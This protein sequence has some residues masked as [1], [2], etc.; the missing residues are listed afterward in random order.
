MKRGE[1]YRVFKGDT[2]DPKRSRVFIVVSR[3]VLIDS[4]YS[5]LICAPVFSSRDG[6][7]TQVPVGPEAGLKHESAIHCDGLVSIHKSRLTDFIGS[8][9]GYKMKQLNEALRIALESECDVP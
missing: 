2:A 1:L 7:S 6:L 8:L 4:R 5:S 3:Q 9:P